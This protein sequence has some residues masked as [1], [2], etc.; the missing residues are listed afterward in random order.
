MKDQQKG[1]DPKERSRTFI[2][3]TS[4]S[5]SIG[6]GDGGSRLGDTSNFERLIG[7]KVEKANQKNKITGKDVGKYLGKKMK[8]IEESQEKEKEGLRI[9]VEKL[10]LRR[11]KSG[12]RGKNLR[13]TIC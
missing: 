1:G 11:K 10:I 5:I 8:F 4:D 9:K 6:G 3:S 13:F 12:L 2:T 7:R